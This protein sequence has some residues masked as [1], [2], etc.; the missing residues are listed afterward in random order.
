MP[1]IPL[2]EKLEAETQTT[3]YEKAFVHQRLYSANFTVTIA[4]RECAAGGV[5]ATNNGCQT[6]LGSVLQWQRI[7][8]QLLLTAFAATLPLPL[9][10]FCR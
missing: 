9:L 2:P 3:K 8:R 1:L 7:Q 4:V 10:H 6:A 5:F